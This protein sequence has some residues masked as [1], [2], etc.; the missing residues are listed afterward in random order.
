MKTC[1]LA[2]DIPESANT[3][4]VFTGEDFG[5]PQSSVCLLGLLIFSLF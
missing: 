1:R 5:F 2:E 4:N 3:Q